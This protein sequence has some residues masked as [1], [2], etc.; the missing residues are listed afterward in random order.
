MRVLNVHSRIDIN[1]IL[2]YNYA[3]FEAVLKNALI[4]T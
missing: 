3:H 4:I 1:L 2:T